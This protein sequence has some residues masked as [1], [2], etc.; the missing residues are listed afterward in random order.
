MPIGDRTVRKQHGVIM[1]H[2]QQDA[3]EQLAACAALSADARELSYAVWGYYISR[4]HANHL[5]GRMG[6]CRFDQHCR[7]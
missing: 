1:V 2:G 6:F 4:D 7:W 5:K 3:V